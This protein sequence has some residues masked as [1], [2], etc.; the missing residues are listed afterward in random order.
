MS[1]IQPAIFALD[2]RGYIYAEVSSDYTFFTNL[3]DGI[4]FFWGPD[5]YSGWIESNAN[6][7][8]ACSGPSVTVNLPL[9][10]GQYYPI[11]F[12]FANAEGPLSEKCPSLP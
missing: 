10:Q 4:N 12:V 7:S 5:A 1:T 8:I 11:R 3:V 9:L 2:N 6:T